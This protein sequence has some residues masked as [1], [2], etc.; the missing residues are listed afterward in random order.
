MV[1]RWIYTSAPREGRMWYF[2]QTGISYHPTIRNCVLQLKMKVR[3]FFSYFI[4]CILEDSPFIHFL[5]T[6]ILKHLNMWYTW[7]LSAA[8]CHRH[9]SPCIHF[10]K[11][12][13]NFLNCLVIYLTAI[14]T[15]FLSFSNILA[16]CMPDLLLQISRIW[17]GLGSWL[18]Y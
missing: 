15:S 12:K 11:I 18:S 2:Y 13:Y 9:R 6:S 3:F 7:S 17:L 8:Y 5:C 14:F 4:V 16:D 10:K 1:I